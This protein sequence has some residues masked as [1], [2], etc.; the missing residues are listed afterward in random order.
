M[1]DGP[2]LPT[3]SWKAAIEVRDSQRL[4][5]TLEKLTQA[6]HTLAQENA[7]NGKQQHAIV[8]QS[9]DADGQRFYS[10]NDQTTGSTVAQY[11]FANGYMLVGPNRP[12]LLEA[13]R[14]YATGNSL[15]RSAAFHSLLPKDANAN[16][17]AVAY[18]NL[19]PVL[20]PLLAQFNGES[21][22]AIQKLAADARPTAIC[23]RAEESR[24]EAFTDSHLFGF[25]FLT[26]GSLVSLGN[27]HGGGNVRE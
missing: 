7:G 5:Q 11:T 24:I 27:H 8:I 4:E 9:S 25:D 13:L 20:G 17:S 23:A 2:V 21:A 6:M 14:T 18:Q 19:S 1:A 12:I 26:L 16:Y 15:A 10:V 22:A 3:P